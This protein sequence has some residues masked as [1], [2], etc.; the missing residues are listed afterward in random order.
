MPI[1]ALPSKYGIGNIGESAKYFLGFLKSAGQSY[2]QVLPVVQTGYG[3]SPYQSVCDASGNP[4]FLDLETLRREGLLTK[5]ELAAAIEKSP[6]IDYGKLYEERYALLR[7]AFS[8]FNVDSPAFCRWK[9]KGEFRDYALF[10]AIKQKYPVNFCE[11]PDALKYRD[12]KALSRF[13]AE[14]SEEIDFWLFLQF[15]FRSQWKKFVSAVHQSGVRLIGDLP[16]YVSADSVDVWVHPELFCLNDDLTPKLV[17]GVPPDYF[18]EKGQLWGNPVYDYSEHAKDGFKWWENRLNRTLSLYDYVR[19]DHFRGLDRFWTVQAPADDARGGCWADGPRTKIFEGVDSSR[20]IAEDLGI[21]DDGV[22][23]L[24]AEC[25]FPGMKVL[26]FAFDGNPNNPYLPAKVPEKCIYYTGTHDNDTVLGLIESASPQSLSVIHAGVKKSLEYF[27]FYGDIKGKYALAEAF[28]DIV[29]A[30]RAD[31]AM[32]P[33]ADLLCLPTA[34]RINRPGETGC[35]RVRFTKRMFTE[36]IAVI[37]KRRCRRF[38][39]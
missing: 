36:N 3:D 31:V 4:Y 18:S 27:G 7:K 23:S 32:T 12:R 15:E 34:Y 20:I 37:S 28:L 19:I 10:M 39:R 9:K 17:A 14:N 8:R 16:L 38:E 11:W 24:L 21:I 26:S 35:W 1:S 29:Y 22:K 33:A 30:S 25:G 5:R 6:L 13:A 2:W